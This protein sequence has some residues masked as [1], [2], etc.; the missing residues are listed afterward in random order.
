M[1]D[2][3]DIDD[4]IA[5]E[6]KKIHA[7]RLLQYG[8]AALEAGA[9]IEQIYVSFSQFKMALAAC[10]RI[11][12]LAKIFDTP[13][14][15]LIT[16]PSGAS[17]TTLAQYFIRSLPPSDLFEA[18]FGAIMFRLRTAPSQG[19]VVSGLLQALKYPFSNVRTG[20]IFAM[21]DVA[22]DALKQRGTRLVFIDQAHCLSNQTKPRHVD[23]LEGA[24]S[25]T[26]REMMEETKVGLVLLADSTFRGLDYVD[27][28]LDD[29]ISVKMSL[30]HFLPGSE[31]L[32]FLRAFCNA[33]KCVDL[34]I[35]TH[36]TIEAA[37]HSATDGNRRSFRRLIV[38]A[39]MV[40]V[41]QGELAIT[42][43][44]L[45]R[46]FDIVHGNAS[47]RSNPYGK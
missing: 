22:F 17:K 12:Q 3:V 16:G 45:K 36:P 8:P 24:A 46:A 31:W 47:S 7:R 29:R 5:V 6:D 41:D 40:A 34:Q 30:S 14:G 26:L 13:H 27:R 1:Y 42:E 10:D 35:L 11:F 32:G 38:E 44:H 4:P 43:V 37:T 25:D 18:D 33:V 28:A 21:R 19:H 15:L 39:V 23:V 20:R 2:F 9:S